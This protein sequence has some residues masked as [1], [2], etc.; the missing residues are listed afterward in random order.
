[1]LRRFV[2]AY[3]TSR[4]GKFLLYLLRDSRRLTAA[5][6]RLRRYDPFREKV[7]RKNPQIFPIYKIINNSSANIVR[8]KRRQF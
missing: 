6:C 2:V 4:A 5:K 1:M 8:A 7:N 3:A